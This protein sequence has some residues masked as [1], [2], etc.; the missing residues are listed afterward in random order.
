MLIGQG[1]FLAT[2]PV[3]DPSSPD[4]WTSL[5][6][7][8]LALWRIEHAERV[9]R[10]HPDF[11]Y[12]GQLRLA[13]GVNNIALGKKDAGKTTLRDLAAHSQTE[14]GQWARRYLTVEGS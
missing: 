11:P 7:R 6:G 3:P 4:G 9:L 13:I 2:I 8:D 14:V 5:A 12:A 1:R 10:E